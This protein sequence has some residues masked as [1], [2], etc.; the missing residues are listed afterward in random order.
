MKRIVL[1][2]GSLGGLI[3]L[4]M[5]I[6][7]VTVGHGESS[8]YGLL[9]GYTN[10]FLAFTMVFFG[11]RAYRNKM[12]GGS[13][14]FLRALGAG[15]LIAMVSATIYVIAWALLCKLAYP[16]FITDYTR[17]SVEQIKKSGLPEAEMQAK[18]RQLESMMAWYRTWPGFIIFSYLEI[19]TVGL[20][21]AVLSAIIL[22]WK[23]KNKKP[24]IAT[25]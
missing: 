25:A 9:I 16:E 2:Y 24:E 18:I 14:S 19:L 15:L 7:L 17:A 13:I 3:V 8:S 22:S 6:L 4:P 12:L 23:R 1:I 20:P 21:M 11:V 10:M 5:L